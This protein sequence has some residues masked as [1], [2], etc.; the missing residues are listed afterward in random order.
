M[1][2]ENTLQR[3]LNRHWFV[4]I[5]AAVIEVFW[6][7]GLKHA[8]GVWAWSGTFVAMVVSNYL[9]IVS[10]RVLPVGTAYAVY[11]G[12]GTVGTVLAEMT[13]FGEPFELVKVLLIL[14]LLSGVI[15]LKVVTEEKTP[16][17]ANS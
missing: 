8:E 10:G 1:K 13:I 17:G 2:K 3:P 9:L 6:V 5:V 12:L 7:I 16:E 14:V 15:G 4:L 11:V